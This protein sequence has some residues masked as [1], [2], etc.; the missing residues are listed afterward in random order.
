M[1]AA[2]AL[3]LLALLAAAAVHAVQVRVGEDQLSGSEIELEEASEIEHSD[4]HGQFSPLV[5]T[6]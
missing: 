3:L 1:R 2:T 6:T 4:N 5:R